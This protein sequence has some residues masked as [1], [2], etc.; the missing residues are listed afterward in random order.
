MKFHDALSQVSW[1]DFEVLVANYYR[2]QGFD[3]MHCGNGTMGVR[4]GG[5][6]DLRMRKDGRLVLVQ[7][8]HESIH[9]VDAAAIERLLAVRA[10]DGAAEAIVVASGEFSADARR[11]AA[12][13]GATLVDGMELRELLGGDRLE[14]LPPPRVAHAIDPHHRGSRIV[15]KDLTPPSRRRRKHRAMLLKLL[16]VLGLVALLVW[17]AP[18]LRQL[19]GWKSPPPPAPAATPAAEPEDGAETVAVPLPAKN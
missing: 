10:E 5:G 18:A 1:Q 17:Q 16:L 6:V 9:P 14:K 11:A 12:E 19:V 3:V 4:G 2:D 7:C 13:G 8:R 15:V